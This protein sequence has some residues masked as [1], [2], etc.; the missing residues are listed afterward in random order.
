MIDKISSSNILNQ[1][2]TGSIKEK[3]VPTF[4]DTLKEYISSVNNDQIA[5]NNAITKF[6]KG[7]TK[8][9]HSTVISIEKAEIS[10]Q[11]M[12]QIKNKLTQAYQE[13]MRMQI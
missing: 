9:I 5:A 10:L 4:S 11:L 1:T 3:K 8:D 6:L 12:L 7:E 13:I 2:L